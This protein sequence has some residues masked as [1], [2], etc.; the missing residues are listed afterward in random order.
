MD[1]TK[2]EKRQSLKVIISEVIMTLAVIITVTI[3]ALIVSGYWLNSDFEVERQGMLQI[4]SVPTGASVNI[5][6]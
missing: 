5:D 6:G 1:R 4:S 2:Q 3:L